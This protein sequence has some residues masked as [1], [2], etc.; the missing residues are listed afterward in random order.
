[1]NV[2]RG[3]HEV[4]DEGRECGRGGEVVDQDG[5]RRLGGQLVEIVRDGL[6]SLQRETGVFRDEGKGEVGGGGRFEEAAIVALERSGE[7]AEESRQFA[8]GL[9]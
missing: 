1:M 6:G 8:L 9:R 3:V 5:V 4:G 7:A 2:R